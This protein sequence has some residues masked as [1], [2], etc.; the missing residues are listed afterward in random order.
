[1]QL[2]NYIAIAVFSRLKKLFT[3]ATDVSIHGYVI[4]SIFS[5]FYFFRVC[6]TVIIHRK[7]RFLSVFCIVVEIHFGIKANH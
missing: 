4:E 6:L 5:G 1:M 3:Q 2:I 7:Y